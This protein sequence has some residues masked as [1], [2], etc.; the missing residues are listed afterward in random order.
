[1][2]P[3]K[4]TKWTSSHIFIILGAD[5]KKEP[6]KAM[7]SA[8]EIV[9]APASRVAERYGEAGIAGWSPLPDVLVFNQH[10]LEL[11]SQD[12]NVLLNLMAHYYFAEDMPFVRP[13]TIAKRMGVGPRSVQR[14]IARLVEKRLIK[15]ARHQNGHV[16]YDLKPLV[17]AL[18]Q[19]ALDRIADKQ[20][21]AKKREME[22]EM[23]RTTLNKA[24]AAK[25]DVRND[26]EQ[27]LMEA[28]EDLN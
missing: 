14:S 4:Q 9:D 13:T 6:V 1:M 11:S 26:D 21:R 15:K 28:F 22:K 24:Q 8:P 12:L 16:A 18:R 10:R 20:A 17:K 19:F 7:I 27:S 3:M 2:T 25:Q 23:N 5:L